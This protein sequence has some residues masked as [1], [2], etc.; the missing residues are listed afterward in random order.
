MTTS[1]PY[2]SIRLLLLALDGKD[3]GTRSHS[4]RV[5]RYAVPVAE[6]LGLGGDSDRVEKLIA[7]SLLHDV[8]N[9]AV[10]DAVLLKPTPLD[11]L[12]YAAA[13]QHSVAGH[14]LVTA[15]GMPE[16]AKIVR[17]HHE[18]FDGTGYPDG[19]A[20][21]DIPL[22]SRIIGVVEA[23]EAMTG[24][25]SYKE[26]RV[27]CFTALDVIERAAG[28]QFDP[29]VVAALGDVIFAG[30]L[31]AELPALP[32]VALIGERLNAADA[33]RELAPR[34]RM[35]GAMPALNG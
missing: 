22:E 20:G 1:L 10:P 30:D 3:P 11:E 8:G 31:E 24:A 32:V 18:R 23:L 26:E 16:I 4:V 34:M 12:E 9:I 7:A 19:L 33:E 21:T 15:A 2:E 29:D 17:H 13:R 28:T 27:C 25:S 35:S 5:A 6:R 14:E